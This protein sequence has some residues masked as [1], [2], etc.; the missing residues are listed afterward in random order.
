LKQ[1]RD[2]RSTGKQRIILNELG[3]PINGTSFSFW[4]ANRAPA[5][6]IASATGENT[7]LPSTSNNHLVT[8]IFLV[9]FGEFY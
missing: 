9:F 4:S 5:S 2:P 6:F 3:A 1:I 8:G 7:A